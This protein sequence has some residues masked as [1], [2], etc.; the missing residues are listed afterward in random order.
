MVWFVLAVILSGAAIERRAPHPLPPAAAAGTMATLPPM[1][2]AR[3]AHSATALPDGRILFT[4]GY[5]PGGRILRSAD[6]YDPVTG[7]FTRVGD[8]TVP[9]ESHVG[10]RLAN[11]QVLVVA[12]VC[13]ATTVPAASTAPTTDLRT[14]RSKPIVTAGPCVSG[15]ASG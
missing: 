8:M 7:R 9:R 11:G 10:V 15:I 4:G 14:P 2:I 13:V 3:M 5:G 12:T 1:R 6:L